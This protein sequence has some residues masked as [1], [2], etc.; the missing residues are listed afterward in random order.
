MSTECNELES[1]RSQSGQQDFTTNDSRPA[2]KRRSYSHL[3]TEKSVKYIE[4]DTEK[5]YCLSSLSSYA[6][7]L[8]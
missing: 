3:H 8:L 2:V 7:L 1:M 5:A 6:G 4:S